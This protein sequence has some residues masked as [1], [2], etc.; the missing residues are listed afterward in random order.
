M[1]NME[2]MKSEVVNMHIHKQ[3]SDKRIPALWK[4]RYFPVTFH[5][6]LSWTN[7]YTISALFYDCKWKNSLICRI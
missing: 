6:V 1:I 5:Y 7:Q 3:I 4:K 2:A